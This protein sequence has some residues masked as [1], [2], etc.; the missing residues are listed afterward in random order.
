MHSLI[1]LKS[2]LSIEVTLNGRRGLGLG[3]VLVTSLLLH[4]IQECMRC[5]LAIALECSSQILTQVNFGN[6]E[7]FANTTD[8]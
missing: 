3:Y 7:Q 1:L 4:N 6:A 5:G 2:I 8:R